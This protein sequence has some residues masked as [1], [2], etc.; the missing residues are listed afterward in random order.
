MEQA[1]SGQSLSEQALSGQSLPE[2]ALS[3]IKV[4]DLTHHIAGPYCTKLLAD[5]GADVLKVEKPGSG[6]PTRKMGPFL[7]DEP[8]PDK[9][10]LFLHLN[11]SK[12]GITLDLKTQTGK[13]IFRQLVKDVDILVEN[14]SPGVM[15]SL[16]LDYKELEKITPKLVM[17][18]I[19]NFGQT[20][21]YRD[22]KASELIIYGMGGAMNETG[23]FDRYPLKKA[24]NVVQYQV[25]KAGTENPTLR[26]TTVA[27]DILPVFHVP[28]LEEVFNQPNETVVMDLFA[29]DA[30]QDCEVNGIKTGA[31]ITLDKPFRSV[32]LL[33]FP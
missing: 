22:F 16:G 11:T 4:L 33:D 21:P 10:S 18:S 9:S 31:N 29:Q 2:Q 3:D 17:T 30:H 24:G 12:R 15:P 26:N 1:L 14:F 20:G 5:Y 8:H 7:G 19:S 32:P 13:K 28:C 25:G 6:D 27:V 23:M